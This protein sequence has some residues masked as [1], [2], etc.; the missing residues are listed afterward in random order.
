[1]SDERLSLQTPAWLSCAL[2]EADVTALVDEAS[3]LSFT[4]LESTRFGIRVRDR[5]LTS[6]Y[7]F[8]SARGGRA[9]MNVIASHDD[10]GEMARGLAGKSVEFSSATYLLYE[11]GSF[12]GTHTDRAGCEINLLFLL[13]GP[14]TS[15]ELFPEHAGT[16]METLLTLARRG[17][18]LLSNG[19]HVPLSAIGDGVVFQ[20]GSIPHQRRHAAAP[21]LLFSAC[22]KAPAAGR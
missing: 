15:L 2:D 6:S 14:A 16:D 19:T 4:H 10:F 22:F 8:A 12:M 18:G 7:D 5:R 20:S 9:A 17:E 3:R 13:R 11:V 1:M 21:L